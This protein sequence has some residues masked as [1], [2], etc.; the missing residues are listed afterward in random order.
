MGKRGGDRR[1]TCTMIGERARWMCE[2]CTVKR[3]TDI[4]R[5]SAGE[6]PEWQTH[7]LLCE[8]CRVALGLT[9]EDV[10]F[11]R[12]M[13]ALRERK[14]VRWLR[15]QVIARDGLVCHL[16]HK[17][18]EPADVHIDHVVPIAT[19]GLSVLPNLKVAHSVCN[20]AKGVSAP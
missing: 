17:D 1:L 15:A 12:V 3:G 10:I 6:G 20:M 5:T 14:R 4:Y 2:R 16:C 8:D 19:G 11:F 13:A 7:A 9:P 18:V